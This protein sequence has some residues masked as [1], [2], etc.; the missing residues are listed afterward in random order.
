[1]N[2]IIQ[3]VPQQASNPSKKERPRNTMPDG[4]KRIRID[5]G[6]DL[7]T[8]KRR[9]KSFYGKTLKECRDKRDAWLAAQNTHVGTPDPKTVREWAGTWRTIYGSGAGYSQ[10]RTVEIDTRRLCDFMGNMQ[11]SD[12]QQVHIQAYAQ[13]VTGYA[14]ST[15]SKIKATTNRIFESAV[16]N[17]YILRNPCLGVKWQHAGEGTH[18]ALEP[19]EIDLIT[20]NWDVHFAGVWAMLMLYAGLRRGEALALR[21]EDVDIEAKALHVKQGVHFEANTPTLGAPKTVNA[22]RD[23]PISPQLEDMLKKAP[24]TCDYVCTGAA[25]QQVTDSIWASGWKAW[26]NTMRN[27]LNGDTKTPV[28]PGHR[29]DRESPERKPFVVRAHDLRHTFATLLYDAGVDVKTAQKLLGHA[30]PEI[31]MGIYTH[32]TSARENASLGQFQ[33][34]FS[35]LWLKSG[36]KTRKNQ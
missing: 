5:I 24:H 30:T 34:Y 12:V 35:D 17:G 21:W 9:L 11:L 18:R 25:G 14:K 6:I 8:G 16:A 29:T 27:I 33:T 36:S 10:N 4:R 7:E 20:Q 19:W 23:V 1:M 26:N 31:T 3:L 15:V 32:L 22:I 28:S 2:K 13:S